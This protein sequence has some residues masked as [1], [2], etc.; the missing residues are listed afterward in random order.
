MFP[1][2]ARAV[3]ARSDEFKLKPRVVGASQ[4]RSNN[5][6]WVQSPGAIAGFTIV[7][8][9]VAIACVYLLWRGPNRDAFPCIKRKE[10]RKDNE[11]DAYTHDFSGRGP[12]NW[13]DTIVREEAFFPVPKGTGVPPSGSEKDFAPRPSRTASLYSYD[14][15]Y[16]TATT[17]NGAPRSNRNSR[18]SFDRT[19]RVGNRRPPSLGAASSFSIPELPEAAHFAEQDQPMTFPAQSPQYPTLPRSPSN[20]SNQADIFDPSSPGLLSV[21]GTYAR[22]QATSPPATAAV[23]NRRSL[24]RRSVGSAVGIPS[25]LAQSTLSDGTDKPLSPE[26]RKSRTV[27]FVEQRQSSSTSSPPRTQSRTSTRSAPVGHLPPGAGEP[28]ASIPPMPQYLRSGGADEA[29]PMP[30]S[31]MSWTGTGYTPEAGLFQSS[32]EAYQL[33]DGAYNPTHPVALAHAKL[34]SASASPSLSS[35]PIFP[36]PT[37]PVAHAY[38]TPPQSPTRRTP[39][40]PG[41]MSLVSRSPSANASADPRSVEEGYTSATL[42][43]SGT[44]GPV[45]SEE[46]AG[47]SDSRSE[48]SSPPFSTPPTSVSNVSTTASSITGEG[49]ARVVSGKKAGHRKGESTSSSPNSS[50]SSHMG[51]LWYD[52][53]GTSPHGI[54]PPTVAPPAR[55]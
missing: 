5:N 47:S 8:S 48:P 32:G 50:S 35:A 25:P 28:H 51:G 33:P 17:A 18:T 53:A 39:A 9:V 37:F 43:S 21:N 30:A 16:T 55:V 24:V 42:S 23:S 46:H 10:E 11:Q 26:R 52:S 36:A 3:Y 38:V 15:R 41:D 13:R 22:S 2:S 40:A 27:S 31:G 7:F 34:S 49:G 6:K 1:N 45:S 54:Q 19:S 12:A 44:H 14:S 29:T 4:D 20:G